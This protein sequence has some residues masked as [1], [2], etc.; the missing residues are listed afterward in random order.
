MNGLQRLA[1][2]S[3]ERPSNTYWQWLEWVSIL[4]PV[5]FFLGYYSLMVGFGHGFLRSVFEVLAL[6][7]LIVLFS[8]LMFDAIRRLQH[9]VQAL[10]RKVST[11][12]SQLRL[13]LEANLALSQEGVSAVAMQRVADLG[14]QLFQADT[15]ILTVV[16]PHGGTAERYCSPAEVDS[17]VHT[18]VIRLVQQGTEPKRLCLEGSGAIVTID[19]DD[20]NDDADCLGVPMVYQQT[21]LGSICFCREADGEGYT[22]QDEELARLF[23][24]Q[25][26]V[27]IHN[28]QLIE[29]IEDVAVL[30]ERDR[31]AREMHDGMAQ[32]LGYINTQTIGIKKLLDDEKLPI[33][34][35]ELSKMEAIARDLYGD[36]REGILGLRVAAQRD[37]GLI[38]ILREYIDHYREMS[39]LEAEA[40]I[41]SE[42]EELGISSTDEIQI[43]RIVQEA[44]TN[45]RKHA[46]AKKVSVNLE[47]VNNQLC[48]EVLDDGKGFNPDELP[49]PGGPRF[50]LRVME[51]RAL[52]LGGEFSINSRLSGGTNVAVK[53]PV[54]SVSGV[55]VTE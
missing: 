38:P 13:L 32:V 12:N 8:R 41:S 24:S 1:L 33:A 2:L 44:L 26:A 36:V 3:A 4:V 50:G 37:R 20:L 22:V 23:A 9:N 35:E 39:G 46:G 19:G 51:E 10:S 43:L 18:G 49:T 48:I 28:A 55:K 47:H 16:G 53:V 29:Q 40:C 15:A 30:Q 27:A 25:A 34:R 45:V 42:V 5:S 52:S 14:R 17:C 7:G 21:L 54:S 6:V 11:Q 31:I